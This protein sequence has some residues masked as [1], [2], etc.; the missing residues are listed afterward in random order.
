MVPFFFFFFFFWA[1]LLSA[2]LLLIAFSFCSFLSVSLSLSSRGSLVLCCSRV[3]HCRWLQP[4]LLHRT[5]L[6]LRRNQEAL[7]LYS[8]VRSLLRFLF[9]DRRTFSVSVCVL[10]CELAVLCAAS[11]RETKRASRRDSCIWRRSALIHGTC[12]ANMMLKSDC[13][14]HSFISARF[15]GESLCH[16]GTGVPPSSLLLARIGYRCRS[17]R[18]RRKRARWL[19]SCWWRVCPASEL[20]CAVQCGPDCRCHGGYS[21]G[22]CFRR[23]SQRLASACE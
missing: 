7:K 1:C 3:S 19:G 10:P 14:C 20:R 22:H 18:I 21:W 16:P 4:V 6:G 5:L 11:A 12:W 15:S 17:Y 23:F 2:V 9:S 13:L 8:P